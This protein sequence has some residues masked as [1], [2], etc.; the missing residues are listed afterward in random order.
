MLKDKIKKKQ[1]KEKTKKQHEW[2]YVKPPNP[3]H[4]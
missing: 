3:W 4:E 1:L 2:T